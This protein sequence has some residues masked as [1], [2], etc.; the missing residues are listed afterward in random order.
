MS[1]YV[2]YNE[3]GYEGEVGTEEGEAK[4]EAYC[5]VVR[6]GNIMYAMIENI[7]NPPKGF[8][9]VIKRHFYI[10]K[11]AILKEVDKWIKRATDKVAKY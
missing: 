4:N 1:E 3:P 7:K 5:N 6:Y 11:N 2:F 8:E 10:K 9:E